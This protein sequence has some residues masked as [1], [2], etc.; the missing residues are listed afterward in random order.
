[1]R[2]TTLT[3]SSSIMT[4]IEPGLDT[5]EIS[6]VR[7]RLFPPSMGNA[8]EN[9]IK[10]KTYKISLARCGPGIA[11]MAAIILRFLLERL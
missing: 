4:R 9:R 11:A 5:R 8:Y 7:S 1:M 3:D 6:W 10:I 2:H